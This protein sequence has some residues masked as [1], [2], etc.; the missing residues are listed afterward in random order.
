[1]AQ[2]VC[3]GATLMC[4]FGTV[5]GQLVVTPEN[6]VGAGGLPAANIADHIPLKNV[7]PFGLCTTPSNPQVSAALGAPQPCIPVTAQ[8][9]IPGSPTV[10]VG[11]QPALQSSC[12]LICQWG[13]II[14]V[15]QPGQLTVNTA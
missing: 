12:Q 8:P 11:P 5:P 13:G 15:Q 10:R 6:R 3:G 2:Q 1:M 14:T 7:L 9:W 4:S